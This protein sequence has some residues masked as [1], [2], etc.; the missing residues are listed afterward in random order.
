L[1]RAESER[2]FGDEEETH[3]KVLVL[4]KKEEEYLMRIRCLVGESMAEEDWGLKKV[5]D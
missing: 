2:Q 4:S 5:L 3:E 1:T